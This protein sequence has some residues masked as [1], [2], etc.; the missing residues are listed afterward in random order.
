ML[1]AGLAGASIGATIINKSNDHEANWTVSR[2]GQ[3]RCG[4]SLL[5]GCAQLAW[6]QSLPLRLGSRLWGNVHNLELPMWM[7]EPMYKG[8]TWMFDC[9]LDEMRGE[10]CAVAPMFAVGSHD[11][12]MCARLDRSS[13]V[14]PQHGC[15]LHALPQ[16]AHRTLLCAASQLV[17]PVFLM[18]VLVDFAFSQ[19]GVRP[20]S[21]AEMVRAE[22][23]FPRA[24]SAVFSRSSVVPLRVQ[25]SPVDAKITV[26]GE[27]RDGDKVDQIKVAIFAG[28]PSLRK[29]LIVA[30]RF[31]GMSYSLRRLIGEAPRMRDPNNRLYY[32]VF[33]LAPGQCP[34]ALFLRLR[35]LIRISLC[36][37]MQATTI[38]S[39]RLPTAR[40]IAGSTSL[41]SSCS[42]VDD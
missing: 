8:W 19:P 17:G 10:R 41:V 7:R 37:A 30:R 5:C 27:V 33:Y 38:A 28:I 32:A 23:V 34:F 42:V 16:G 26:F 18:R 40:C 3:A 21:S 25:I 31:Q 29:S 39:I 20:I 6:M 4:F 36:G 24:S 11:Y 14:V 22:P 1:L 15:V 2:E 13:A 9:K 35:V 12:V